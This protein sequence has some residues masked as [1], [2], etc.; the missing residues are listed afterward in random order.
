MDSA[1]MDDFNI[2]LGFDTIMIGV[3]ELNV[4]LFQNFSQNRPKFDT[5]TRFDNTVIRFRLTIIYIVTI[6]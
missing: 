2:F 1:Y 6:I 4:G 5:L 3:I